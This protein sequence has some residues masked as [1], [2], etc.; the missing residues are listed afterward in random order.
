MG[1]AWTHVAELPDVRYVQPSTNEAGDTLT[2]QQVK[3]LRIFSESSNPNP[4]CFHQ[5]EI[6]G[7]DGINY[8]LE[9]RGGSAKQSTNCHPEEKTYG[10]ASCV[11]DGDRSGSFNETEHVPNG[12]LEVTLSEPRWIESFALFN[13]AFDSCAYAIGHHVQLR[14]HEDRVVYAHQ[15]SVEEDLALF[16]PETQCCLKFIYEDSKTVMLKLTFESLAAGTVNILVTHSLSGASLASFE[17]STEEPEG[18]KTLC[19]EIS[20]RTGI[21]AHQQRLVLEDDQILRIRA[22]SWEPLGSLQE[23][24]PNLLQE[25]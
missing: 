17:I 6:Y 18:V 25:R 2:W 15:F 1:G 24:C 11:I 8:A 22:G 12:W 20:V 10:H 7:E 14:D 13:T 9:V 4:I 5:I 16:N 3:K 19:Q 23:I 21:P